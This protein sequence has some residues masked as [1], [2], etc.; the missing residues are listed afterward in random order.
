MKA[1]EYDWCPL[2]DPVSSATHLFWCLAAFFF[3][4]LLLRLAR[5]DR[6]RWWSVACFGFS[7]CLLYG[8]S[9][10]YH[11]LKVE[12][13]VLEY[14]R[15]IDHSAI[16]VL[17]AG[18]ATPIFAV[19]LRGRLRV[20]LLSLIWGMAAIG[21]ACKWLLPAP[22]YSVTVGLYIAMGW[23]GV[24]PVV[25]VIRAIGVR[26]MAWAVLGGLLYTA[27]GIADAMRW[28]VIYPGVVGAHEVLHVL[29]MGGTLSHIVLIIR[30]VLPFQGL[31]VAA[32]C[33]RPPGLEDSPGALF[34]LQ[35][36]V[37]D[38]ASTSFLEPLGQPD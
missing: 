23:V 37:V 36:E 17:I 2:R 28:P 4:A 6:L 27:G 29:D 5:G 9:G 14:F 34:P 7:M 26:G 32:E 16:Y 11:A 12:P 21:I 31:V 1:W 35:G 25:Q 18:S 22:I 24:I 13:R 33:S 10:I 15:L 20:Y 30:Y 8:A 3:T 19:L 38:P